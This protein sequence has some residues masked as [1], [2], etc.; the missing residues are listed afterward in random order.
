M[1]TI[2][3][4][5]QPYTPAITL[6]YIPPTDSTIHDTRYTILRVRSSFHF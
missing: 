2:T 1:L 4:V 6:Y 5:Y 3:L